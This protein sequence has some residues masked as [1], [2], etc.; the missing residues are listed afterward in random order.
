MR[1]SGEKRRR[2]KVGVNAREEFIYS[3]AYGS[4]DDTFG[5]YE[6]HVEDEGGETRGR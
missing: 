4:L 1:V 6:L 2:R 5:G 3:V